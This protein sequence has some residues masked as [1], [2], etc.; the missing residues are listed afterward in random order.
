MTGS[1]AD[2]ANGSFSEWCPVA[3][4]SV[5]SDLTPRQ[6]HFAT[7]L[8]PSDL[9]WRTFRMTRFHTSLRKGFSLTELMVVTALGLLVL[10]LLAP[11]IYAACQQPAARTATI[12]N[13]KQIAI[14]LHAHNDTFKKLPPAYDK[15]LGFK[16]NATV[17]V[18]ILPYVEQGPLYNQYLQQGGGGDREKVEIG[19]FVSPLDNTNPK[20]PSGIQN[21]A[22]NL[23][24]FGNSTAKYD[25]PVPLADTMNA[26]ARIPGSF[27]DGTSN[28]IV[29]A[30]KY[31]VCG[32]GGSR[33]A[34]PPKSDTAAF[35]GQ[36]PATVKADPAD[37]KA[38][39]Q[40]QP[41]AKQCLCSPLM[42]QSYEKAGL[43]VALADGSTRTLNPNLSPQTWNVALHPSDG[44]PLGEDWNN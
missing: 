2:F 16:T 43:L 1:A 8:S 31:G 17:H 42:A 13:L 21:F 41:S 26:N 18:Y 35:F 44:M 3:T 22:A 7:L 29:F 19:V 23:R 12:N 25:A 24:V 39:F 37:P 38:T 28:T 36:N 34:S 10:G 14:A 5:G 32:K 9:E 15:A 40:H 4:L 33:Y 11:A 27:P 6:L 30:T 20:P